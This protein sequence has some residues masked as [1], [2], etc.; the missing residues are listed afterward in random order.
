M[1]VIRQQDEYII[2]TAYAS[3]AANYDYAGRDEF[4]ISFF[5]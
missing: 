5:A 4:E 2:C 3:H 1:D